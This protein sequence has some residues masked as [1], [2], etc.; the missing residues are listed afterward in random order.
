MKGDRYFFL[1]EWPFF[2]ELRAENGVARSL[3][4]SINESR[5][6]ETNEWLKAEEEF[7]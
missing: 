6:K 1:L 4:K 7:T 3:I 5:L 2:V